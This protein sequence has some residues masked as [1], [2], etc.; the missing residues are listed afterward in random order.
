MWLWPL[1]G[2]YLLEVDLTDARISPV[3]TTP[4][5]LSSSSS[6]SSCSWGIVPR[7]GSVI[8]PPLV[9]QQQ[10]QAPSQRQ[11]VAV[12]FVRVAAGSQSSQQ[13]AI[14]YSGPSVYTSTTLEED[15]IETLA[16]TSDVLLLMVA[17]ATESS[18]PRTWDRVAA[19]I[20][21]GATRRRDAGFPKLAV[22]LVVSTGIPKRK[23]DEDTLALS[24]MDTPTSTTSSSSSTL[25]ESSWK[26]QILSERLAD[27]TPDLVASLDI[28]SETTAEATYQDV[29]SD[30]PLESIVTDLEEYR[31]MIQQVYQTLTNKECDIVFDTAKSSFFESSGDTNVDK[32]GPASLLRGQGS[33]SVASEA[34]EIEAGLNVPEKD[35]Q[36]V[37][38]D[39]LDDAMKE[40]EDLESQ[41]QEVWLSSDAQVPML[42]FGSIANGILNKASNAVARAPSHVR[43]AVLQQLARKLRILYDNQLQSLRE[44]FGRKYEK[45]LEENPHDDEAQVAS[46]TRI[47]D[48]FRVAAQHAIPA[49]CREGQPLV[50]ADFSYVSSLQ[51]LLSDMMEAT[52]MRQ[53]VDDDIDTADAEPMPTKWYKKVAA[54][55][56]MVGVNYIQGW[57]AWQG[58]KK[59]AEQRD[60]DM[61]KFPLF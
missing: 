59:A 43:E 36:A 17:E 44:Q 31:L 9:Q 34:A 46:I 56:L 54:Q 24:E 39:L 15:S 40:F 7:G 26:E 19:S 30:L 18:L 2:C 42:H 12:G 8:N 60:K 22:L 49:Q 27:L 47:T 45:V 58:I 4:L 3:I 16:I 23:D 52:S 13:L 37:N 28:A 55:I 33:I 5:L 53:D 29:I 1:L 41:Q 20:V 38:Q 14:F 6:S 50:D 51:G 57:L 25:S 35:F 10:Q 11:Q 48:G 32:E 61:P 21:K